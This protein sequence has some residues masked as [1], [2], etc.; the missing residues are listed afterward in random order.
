M[1]CMYNKSHNACIFHCQGLVVFP[2]LKDETTSGT[3]KGETLPLKKRESE[4]KTRGETLI[5]AHRGTDGQ[6]QK[7]RCP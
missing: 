6:K 1:Y 2:L 4:R 7:E 3:E 5:L